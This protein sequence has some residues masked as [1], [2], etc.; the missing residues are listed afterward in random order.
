VVVATFWIMAFVLDA[1]LKEVEIGGG[2][3][4]CV[5]VIFESPRYAQRIIWPPFVAVIAVI[6]SAQTQEMTMKRMKRRALLR[7]RCMLGMTKSCDQCTREIRDHRPKRWWRNIR[8][9]GGRSEVEECSNTRLKR[10]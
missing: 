5:H 8:D 7:T 2:P 4:I 6:G 3:R 1:L 9:I 10:K